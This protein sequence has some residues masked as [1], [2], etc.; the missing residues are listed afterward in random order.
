MIWWIY[1]F[2]QLLEPI[3][4]ATLRMNAKMNSGLGV[5]RICHGGLMGTHVTPGGEL[6][7]DEAMGMGKPFKYFCESKLL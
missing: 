3:K 4:C 5:I 6:L 1:I 2:I 7:I